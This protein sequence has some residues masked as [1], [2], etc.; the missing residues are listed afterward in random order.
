[1]R[2]SPKNTKSPKNN[3]NNKR[4]R[5]SLSPKLNMEKKPKTFPNTENVSN[6]KRSTPELVETVETIDQISEKKKMDDK[7]KVNAPNRNCPTCQ[8]VIGLLN[9]VE[10][11]CCKE[12]FHILCVDISE[13]EFKSLKKLGEKV[14]WICT[15]CDN[16]VENI[17]KENMNLKIRIVKL[18]SE[19]EKINR[20]IRQ[21][22]PAELIID[23]PDELQITNSPQEGTEV[24][25]D[26]SDELQNTNGHQEEKSSTTDLEKITDHFEKIK[27]EN[28]EIIKNTVKETLNKELKEVLKEELKEYIGKKYEGNNNHNN[29]EMNKE[30]ERQCNI[31]VYNIKENCSDDAEHRKS[32]DLRNVKEVFERGLKV[33]NYYIN[34]VIRLG[35]RNDP[36]RSGNKPRPLL[37]KLENQQQKWNLIKSARNLKHAPDGMNIVGISLDLHVWAWSIGIFSSWTAS[38]WSCIS[39]RGCYSNLLHL[40]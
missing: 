3:N 23:N 24:I 21:N 19:I 27:L 31:I 40:L 12:R 11:R 17:A 26:N 10:C 32:W 1:M 30:E 20:G 13:E 34:N 6:K 5:N 25:I 18:E 35:K 39:C 2:G 37:V 7:P 8:C 36:E 14:K 33:D 22:M 29:N 16:S 9:N 15:D 28:I 38:A 4:K